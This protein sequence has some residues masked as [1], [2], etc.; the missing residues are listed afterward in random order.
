[1]TPS[2]DSKHTDELVTAMGGARRDGHLAQ[3]D[4][5]TTID[6]GELGDISGGIIDCIPP[7]PP[8]RP[9]PDG[10][11][12]PSPLPRPGGLPS[13]LPGPT[14]PLGPFY[15]SQPKSGPV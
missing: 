12:F 7:F 10:L 1:M 6:A 9:R 15:P 8:E 5:P 3:P 4:S 11:P 13:P 14:V 2:V